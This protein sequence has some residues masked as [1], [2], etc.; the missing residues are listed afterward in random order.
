MLGLL[1]RI[2]ERRTFQENQRNRTLN[3]VLFEDPLKKFTKGTN[4][5]MQRG[6]NLVKKVQEDWQKLVPHT[7][8]NLSTYARPWAYGR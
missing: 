4:E 3:P 1:H 2:E 6:S 7:E 5:L 8:E